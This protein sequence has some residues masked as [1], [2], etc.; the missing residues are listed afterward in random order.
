MLV[1]YFKIKISRQ[2]VA[3]ISFYAWYLLIYSRNQQARGSVGGMRFSAS[4]PFS[5]RDGKT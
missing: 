3:Y 2:S 1:T 4:I 5:S